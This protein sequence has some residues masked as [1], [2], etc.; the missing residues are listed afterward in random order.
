[1]GAV[2]LEET[3]ILDKNAANREFACPNLEGRCE[4]DLCKILANFKNKL[5]IA[6]EKL[7]DAKRLNP[8]SPHENYYDAIEKEIIKHAVNRNIGDFSRH[9]G[10]DKTQDVIKGIESALECKPEH[11]CCVQN[12]D[13]MLVGKYLK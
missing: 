13:K 2:S 5:E 3:Q 4:F 12:L 6:C 1:M 8:A 7:N 11:K 10:N 9:I